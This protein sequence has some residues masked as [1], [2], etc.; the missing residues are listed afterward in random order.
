MCQNF[1]FSSYA[2]ILALSSVIKTQIRVHCPKFGGENG[3]SYVT[4]FN[5]VIFPRH[6]YE[7]LSKPNY[8]NWY[9]IM[10]CRESFCEK[11]KLN[12]FAPLVSLKDFKF[13]SRVKKGTKR[14]HPDP[15]VNKISFPPVPKKPQSASLKSS[16]TIAT[17]TKPR[18]KKNSPFQGNTIFDTYLFK[19]CQIVPSSSSNIVTSSCA[20]VTSSSQTILTT[21]SNSTSSVSL[22]LPVMSSGPAAV[23][24]ATHQVTFSSPSESASAVALSSPSE[25]SSK[26]SYFSTS[27]PSTSK[28]V[29]KASANK[30]KLV[31]SYNSYSD[32]P[33][34]LRYDVSNYFA[35]SKNLNDG[36]R[37]DL[38]KNCFIPDKKLLIS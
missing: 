22:S 6:F 25:P 37:Y 4:L 11:G 27:L 38:I 33:I 18:C 32:V 9:D 21:V 10:F 31:Q 23:I 30:D 1:K 28:T 7:E 15:Q 12:H 19:S 24:P 14:G 8:L 5:S 16:K 26:H 35:I 2:C 34:E 20:I 13:Q 29:V 36:E 17:S 3:N